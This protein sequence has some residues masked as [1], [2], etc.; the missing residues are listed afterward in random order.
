MQ[1]VSMEMFL[2]FNKCNIN[3][4]KEKLTPD[5]IKRIKTSYLLLEIIDK[6]NIDI[7]DEEVE[8][9]IGEMAQNYEVSTDEIIENI[10]GKDVI[11]YDLKMQKALNFLREN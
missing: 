6:E 5:A 7:T 3:E 8:K 10:G 2:S 11:A 1:G 4:F 9:A